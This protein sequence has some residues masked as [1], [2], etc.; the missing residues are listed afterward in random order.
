MESIGNE[1]YNLQFYPPFRYK[2]EGATMTVS[3]EISTIIILVLMAIILGIVMGVKLARPP[4][5]P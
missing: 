5:R 4:Y 3:V 1:I 2:E